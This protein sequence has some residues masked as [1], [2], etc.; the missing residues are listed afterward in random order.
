[1]LWACN[2]QRHMALEK[3]K[4]AGVNRAVGFAAR[5]GTWPCK[6]KTSTRRRQPCCVC[7]PQQTWPRSKQ[8]HASVNRAWACSPQRNMSLSKPKHTQASTVLW[9][10]PATEHDRKQKVSTRKRQPCCGLAA[11]SGMAPQT[12]NQA[13]AGVN[14]AVGAARSRIWPRAKTQALRVPSSIQSILSIAMTATRLSMGDRLPCHA[15]IYRRSNDGRP[16]CLP[17]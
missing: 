10:W 9:A 13:Y 2:P 8:A 6:R 7:C 11:H 3:N 12:K 14:R 16:A 5:S 4:H 1:M 15:I 17:S